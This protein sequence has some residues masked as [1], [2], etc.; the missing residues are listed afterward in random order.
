MCAA[1]RVLFRGEGRRGVRRVSPW[2]RGWPSP[3]AWA[4]ACLL[5]PTLLVACSSGGGSTA[6]AVP[7]TATTAAV[8]TGG[9]RPGGGTPT[10]A[11]IATAPP[12]PP[13]PPASGSPAASGSPTGT[14]ARPAT[15]GTPATP[16]ASPTRATPVPGPVGAVPVGWRVYQGPLPFAIAYPADWRVDEGQL[17]RNLIYFY[18][19][20]GNGDTF[21][22]VGTT[23]VGEAN[24]NLDVLRDSWFKSRVV[25]CARSAVDQTG[26]ETL[27]GITYA[28]VG[29]TCDLPTGLAYSYT[30]LGVRGTVPWIFEFNAP[31]D[32]YEATLASIFRPMIATLNVYGGPAAR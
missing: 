18:A 11:T 17:D 21:V 6:T 4:L 26:R 7:A 3:V 12:T 25:G 30:G 16:V 2:C 24:I 32:R 14:A 1:I 23:G 31:Y 20:G 19:P 8:A 10:P 27:N 22:V 9:P 5:I 15:V 28:T 13:T 29:A